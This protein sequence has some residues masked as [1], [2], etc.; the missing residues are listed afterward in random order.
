[1][2]LET[3][4]AGAAAA[5]GCRISSG[6]G[7]LEQPATVAAG[8]PSIFGHWREQREL[9]DAGAASDGC[10][11]SSLSQALLEQHETEAARALRGGGGAS[12]QSRWLR[13]QPVRSEGSRSSAR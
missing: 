13:V 12:S 4:V 2:Q 11:G 10:Y 6:W 3:E 1:M 7:L 9:N 8:R 5:G